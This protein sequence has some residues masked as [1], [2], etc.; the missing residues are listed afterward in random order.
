MPRKSSDQLADDLHDVMAETLPSM[1]KDH[2]TEQVKKQVP[3]Q[4]RD[5]VPGI[6]N[7]PPNGVFGIEV[8]GSNSEG[9]DMNPSNNEL[10][11][12]NSDE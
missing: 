9:F 2:V 4:V 10:R 5:Q 8:Y 1:V 12:C 3:E 6:R 11:L 7:V